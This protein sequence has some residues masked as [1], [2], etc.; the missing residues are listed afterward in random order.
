MNMHDRNRFLCATAV[1]LVAITATGLVACAKKSGHASFA[2]AEEAVS[3]MIEAGRAGDSAR[4][5]E[6]F[7]PGSDTI[8]S[9]G[10]AVADKTALD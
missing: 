4:L 2:S 8:L 1:A 10:D 6:I 5:K 7:G 3:A 9:S